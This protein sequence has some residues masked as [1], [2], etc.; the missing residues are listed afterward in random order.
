VRN[1]LLPV[2]IA[3]VAVL[4]LSTVAIAQ[5]GP[6]KEIMAIAKQHC[7]QPGQPGTQ[8]QVLCSETKPSAPAPKHDISG[9]WSGPIGAMRGD[10]IPP[11]TD[12]GKKMASVN[13]GNGAVNVADSNDPLNHC[14]PLGF[15]RN[16]IFELRGLAIGAMP[17][18]VL[19][20]SQY[21][22]I[23]REVWTD[24][25]ANQKNAGG[26]DPSA[27]DARY[28]GYSVGH[29]DGDYTFVVDTV[30]TDDTT[31]LDSGGHPH[32]SD[33]HVIERYERVDHD[34]LKVSVTADDPKVYAKP[35]LLG[36]TI[37]KWIPD[38]QFEEQLCI[39]S[40]AQAY[41]D[42]IAGPA[43]AKK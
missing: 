26:D 4:T 34:T 16:A 8:Y 19:I 1:R 21:E 9:S 24:G 3:L 37:Y 39:P 2:L 33:L 23:W 22:R 10:P 35:F 32:S 27:P 11:M 42:N 15:P 13:H 7:G 38:Q 29:W 14:D 6:S 41:A 18:R 36:T 25:R 43:G 30:G 12:L 31:W 40:E 20:L 28:Y 5:V 17:N